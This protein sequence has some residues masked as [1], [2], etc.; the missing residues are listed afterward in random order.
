MAIFNHVIWLSRTSTRVG[1]YHIYWPSLGFTSNCFRRLS[2]AKFITNVL[3]EGIELS[4]ER[5]HVKA[6]KTDQ[7]TIKCDTVINAAGAHAYHIAE[8]I[9]FTDA[10][11]HWFK[12]LTQQQMAGLELPIIPVRHEYVITEPTVP[13][14]I[15]PKLPVMRIPGTTI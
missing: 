13:P 8:V 15:T 12:K 6:V 7:G 5:T 1:V 9:S 10:A 11:W 4:P 3:V 2:G 14:T